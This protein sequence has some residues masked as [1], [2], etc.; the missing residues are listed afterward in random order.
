M[1]Q[2]VGSMLFMSRPVPATPTSGLQH[3]VREAEEVGRAS[4]SLA[5][6]IDALRTGRRGVSLTAWLIETQ[7]RTDS[8]PLP[9][10]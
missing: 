1:I 4:T 5:E 10:K 8:E 2:L 6:H 7:S 9:L 3:R